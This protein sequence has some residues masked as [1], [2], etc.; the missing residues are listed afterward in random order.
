MIV[1]ALPSGLM[2]QTGSVCIWLQSVAFE[3]GA[4]IVPGPLEGMEA[5]VGKCFSRVP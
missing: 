1:A 5:L 2:V 4:L 3:G